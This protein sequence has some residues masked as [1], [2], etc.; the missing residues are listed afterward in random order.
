MGEEMKIQSELMQLQA[1]AYLSN[2]YPFILTPRWFA[3]EHFYNSATKA[4]NIN[5]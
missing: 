1:H 5:C 2:T 3:S 4:P